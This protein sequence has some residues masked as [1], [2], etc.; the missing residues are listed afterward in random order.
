VLGT[1]TDVAY[2]GKTPASNRLIAGKLV[3]TYWYKRVITGEWKNIGVAPKTGDWRSGRISSAELAKTG[4]LS[5][6]ELTNRLDAAKKRNPEVVGYINI[7]GTGIHYPVVQGPDNTKYLTKSATGAKSESGAIFAD[8]RCSPYVKGDAA[9]RNTILYGHNMKDGSM[10]GR[11]DD[12]GSS[13]SFYQAHPLIQYVD[14]AGN[15]GL[16]RIY[17][18]RK[19]TTADSV[20][21]YPMTTPYARRV[22]S[23]SAQSAVD[24][25]FKP[26]PNGWSLTL[27]TC[28]YDRADG[29]GRILVQGELLDSYSNGDAG[30]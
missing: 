5:R 30:N 18:V 9:A 26:K 7:P 16:W 14:A 17:S 6:E 28:T 25:G 23:W 11:I 15:G 27:S 24:V 4:T 21:T 20:Y 3:L 19:G 22:A 12:Y 10:F 1:Y 13:S 29:T 2:V 8:V